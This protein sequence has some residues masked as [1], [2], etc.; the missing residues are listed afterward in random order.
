[1]FCALV[2][3]LGLSAELLLFVPFCV[4]SVLIVGG[5]G[6]DC[7][8][9]SKPG[10]G[11]TDDWCGKLWPIDGTITPPSDAACAVL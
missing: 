2:S 11:T 10:A 9:L 7:C 1:M 8:V 3:E 5:C 6:V 4:E